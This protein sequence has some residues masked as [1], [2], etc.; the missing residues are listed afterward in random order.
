MDRTERELRLYR[1]L[2]LLV[3]AVYL[4]WWLAVE[5]M[6]P[7]AYNPLLGRL[8]KRLAELTPGD[9][10]IS[11]FANSGTEAVEGALKL[12]RAATSRTKIVG[13]RDAFHG[14]TFGA[15]SV[16]GRPYYRSAYAPLVPDV[17]H[18]PF[19]DVAALEAQPERAVA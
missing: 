2:S 9:L 18:V 17:V 7:H 14:K 15:L 3:G 6:L 1:R 13:T 19:G 5:A 8:A 16:S 12:A 11:F 10:K 4:V